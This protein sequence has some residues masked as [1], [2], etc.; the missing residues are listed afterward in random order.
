MNALT[1]ENFSNMLTA[2]QLQ[3]V[4][5]LLSMDYDINDIIRFIET[6]DEC[7]FSLDNF[8]EVSDILAEIPNDFNYDAIDAIETF[9]NL[10]GM[11]NI[12]QFRESFEGWFESE[13]KFAEKFLYD[14]EY[15]GFDIPKYVLFY[16]DF[17]ALYFGELIHD[18]TFESGFVFRDI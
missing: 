11:K 1:V 3:D 18:F 8:I 6:F 12:Y 5:E 2:R 13:A 10:Y 4:M 16:V 17:D 7:D 9:V 15:Q 14:Q